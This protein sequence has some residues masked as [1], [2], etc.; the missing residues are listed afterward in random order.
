M[1]QVSSRHKHRRR[2]QLGGDVRSH[3]NCFLGKI[4]STRLPPSLS[5]RTINTEAGPVKQDL[6]GMAMGPQACGQ[7]WRAPSF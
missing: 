7:E 6:T 5:R 3:F 1:M 2:F 4:S